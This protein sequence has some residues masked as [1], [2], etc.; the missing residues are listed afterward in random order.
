MHACTHTHVH[1]HVTDVYTCT[2]Y[3][4]TAV[5]SPDL[6]VE[7][8]APEEGQRLLSVAVHHCL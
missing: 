1:A 4:C 8:D 7:D 3:I 2:L 5:L 6:E